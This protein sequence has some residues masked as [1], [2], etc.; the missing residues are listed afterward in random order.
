VSQEVGSDRNSQA[1]AL[2]RTKHG[3]TKEG[4][5]HDQPQQPRCYPRMENRRE[6]QPARDRRP[7]QRDVD[8]VFLVH[9]EH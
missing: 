8:S 5:W 3:E 9:H 1:G 2:S 6:F 4:W 7:A